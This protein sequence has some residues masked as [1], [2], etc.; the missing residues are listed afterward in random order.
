LSAEKLVAG[1]PHVR[2]GSVDDESVHTH[3]GSARRRRDSAQVVTVSA[4]AK[5]TT[6]ILESELAKVVYP[7]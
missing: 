5:A 3:G 2:D 7:S 6:A 1:L 4:A